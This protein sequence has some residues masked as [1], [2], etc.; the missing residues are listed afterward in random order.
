MADNQVINKS[1]VDPALGEGSKL[2]DN[3][4]QLVE[5]ALE[6]QMI[7][8]RL[9]KELLSDLKMIAQFHGVGYQPLMRDALERFATAEVKK[10]AIEYANQKAEKQKDKLPKSALTSEPHGKKAA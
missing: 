6:L 4:E 2:P 3:M 7:S 10:I 5:N 9:S 1:T 8:I